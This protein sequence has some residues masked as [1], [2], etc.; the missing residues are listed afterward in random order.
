MNNKQS[1]KLFMFLVVAAAIS[2][3]VFA[4]NPTVSRAISGDT[5]T[6]TFASLYSNSNQLDEVLSGGAVFVKDS[7]AGDYSSC[8]LSQNDQKLKCAITKASGTITYKITGEGS[9]TGSISS[10]NPGIGDSVALSVSGDSQFSNQQASLCTINDWTVGDWGACDKA[11]GGT[12]TRSV[13]KIIGST[14]TE[15][16]DKPATTQSC[17]GCQEGQVCQAD[18]ACAPIGPTKLGGDCTAQ[19]CTIGLTCKNVMGSNMCTNSGCDSILTEVLSN[20]NNFASCEKISCQ[21]DGVCINFGGSNK[22]CVPKPQFDIVKS[23]CIGMS[24][25]CGV[26]SDGG[27]LCGA[28]V[29]GCNDNAQC[30]GGLKCGGSNANYDSTIKT[31]VID[32]CVPQCNG[33]IC[34][35]DGCGGSCGNCQF[36]VEDYANY[37]LLSGLANTISGKLI[38]TKI[39]FLAS[40]LKVYFGGDVGNDVNGAIIAD[41]Q[42]ELILL[43]DINTELTNAKHSNLQKAS[44]IAKLLK[45]YK[46]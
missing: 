13:K 14:C 40:S 6:L 46:S 30:T 39:I 15:E 17:G 42:S 38:T 19:G 1:I 32:N 9:V 44:H 37:A 23:S 20:M 2:L 7:W 45:D 24:F 34:G 35:D 3:A 21:N 43:Q 26:L 10:F 16:N 8:S 5:A 29:G 28:E 36:I 41:S 11:C 18:G 12:K 25:Y 4:A 33:N 31:C 22:L 27:E